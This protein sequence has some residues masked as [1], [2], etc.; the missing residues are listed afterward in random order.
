MAGKLRVG[1]T[2]LVFVGNVVPDRPEYREGNYSHAANMWQTNLLTALAKQGLAPAL[3]LS[4]RLTRSY[5]SS[6]ILLS[7]PASDVLDNAMRVSILPFI[8]YVVFRQV[9]IGFAVLFNIVAWGWQREQRGKSKVVMSYNL[10]EPSGIFTWIA[11]RLIGA[12]TVCCLNDINTIGRTMPDTLADRVAL[13]IERKTIPLYDGRTVVADAIA[14]DFAPGRSYLRVAGAVEESILAQ[15]EKLP[16][17]ES[18]QHST[19]NFVAT[20]NLSEL[21]GFK[22]I[23]EGFTQTKSPCYRLQI[24][25]AGALQ[26]KIEEAAKSDPRIE[27]LGQLPFVEVLE[28]Y[29]SA[30]C[31][32]CMR[33]TKRVDTRYFFPSKLFEYLASGVP[34]ITTRTGHVESEYQNIAVLLYEETAEA[35]AHKMDEVAQLPLVERRI[36]GRAAA[37]YMRENATWDKVGE[38]VAEY[39]IGLL[40]SDSKEIGVR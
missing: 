31:L 26:D 32:I 3:I 7:P 17:D 16:A 37:R 6:K 38:N 30:D 2:R 4:Q 10:L 23:V 13:W 18:L 33:L 35:L 34:V 28:L 20:G 21:N 8:N 36:L 22:E 27:F 14:D 40:G 24:A 1:D 12:T 25:G 29:K 15:Y 5:R 11:G 9:T 39:I 19:F